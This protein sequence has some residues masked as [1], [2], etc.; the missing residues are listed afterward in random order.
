MPL[1]FNQ[2]LDGIVYQEVSQPSNPEYNNTRLAADYGYI[3]GDVLG[4]S[5]HLRVTITPDQATIEY[6]RAYLLKDEK[7]GQKNGQ[8][9]Y[10][11]IN[12]IIS[13]DVQPKIENLLS[14]PFP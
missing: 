3:H 7:G 10:Q 8:V 5:G 13:S 4:S 14:S 6:V 9:D 1:L 11:C 2:E 12:T